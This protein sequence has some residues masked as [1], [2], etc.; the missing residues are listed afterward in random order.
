M[1][2]SQGQF[3]RAA[4]LWE[5]A[6][7]VRQI[8]GV[9]LPPLTHSLTGYEE[10][11][12]AVRVELGQEA[13]EEAWI[14]GGRMALEQAVEYALSEEESAPL[15]VPAT[16]DQPAI[17]GPLQHVLSRREQ[18]IAILI[19]QGLTNRQIASVL[20][21][22]EHTAATHIAK[23]LKKLGFHSRS[24]IATWI[25]EQGLFALDRR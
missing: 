8:C 12:G 7:A 23:I 22:S 16:P 21:I 6:D 17:P 25:T 15:V 19:A 20:S 1:A 2:A 10:R 5:A 11:V 4:R 9:R 14:E 3:A 13:F 24:Q 18:A